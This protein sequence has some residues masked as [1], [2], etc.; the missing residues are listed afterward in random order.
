[1]AAGQK[2]SLALVSWWTF[3]NGEFSFGANKKT[4]HIK[5]YSEVYADH[6]L[7]LLDR[8]LGNNK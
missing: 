1:M 7:F 8:G 2:R 5:E 4:I 3:W 6:E